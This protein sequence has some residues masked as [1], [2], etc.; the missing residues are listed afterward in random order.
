MVIR[1]DQQLIDLVSGILLDY[2]QVSNRPLPLSPSLSLRDDLAIESLSLVSVVLRLGDEFEVD[3]VEM[4]FEMRT[5]ETVGSLIEL[6][7]TLQNSEAP[8]S[9][10]NNPAV[11][12]L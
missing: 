3:V 1:N 7:R 8:Y 11:Q 10:K 5:L 6:A 9:E 2:A 4:G 12:S